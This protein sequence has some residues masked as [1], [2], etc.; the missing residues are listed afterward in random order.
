MPGAATSPA[1]S[2]TSSG[3][4]TT[5]RC[6]TC[7]NPA[8]RSR[9]PAAGGWSAAGRAWSASSDARAERSGSVSWGMR[10]FPFLVLPILGAAASPPGTADAP[11][12]ADFPSVAEWTTLDVGHRDNYADPSLPAPD[13]DP[14][15]TALDNGRH[16]P[17]TDRGATLGRA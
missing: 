1:P 16:D 11:P 6:P 9:R 13:R 4:P 12:A 17:I 15:V 10:W 3:G 14:A 8:P 7:G 5:G 2:A